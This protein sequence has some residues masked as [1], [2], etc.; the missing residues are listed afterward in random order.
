MLQPSRARNRKYADAP[1]GSRVWYRSLEARSTGSRPRRRV[2]LAVGTGQAGG[3]DAVFGLPA[4]PAGHF[5][6]QP[7]L[8]GG[9]LVSLGSSSRASRALT[10]A[11]LSWASGRSP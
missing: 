10:A 7:G 9:Q 8:S 2:S 5:R 3:E 1:G 6:A 11:S 4:G